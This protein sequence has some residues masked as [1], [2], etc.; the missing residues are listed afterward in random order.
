[1]VRLQYKRYSVEVELKLIHSPHDCKALLLD[2][3]VVPLCRGQFLAAVAHRVGLPVVNLHQHCADSI[4]RRIS[5]K[6]ESLLGVG[7]SQDGSPGQHSSHGLERALLGFLPLHCV[8]LSL[9]QQVRKWHCYSCE[10][11]DIFPIVVG[12]SHEEA[13]LFFGGRSG[14]FHDLPHVVIVQSLH[15]FTQPMSNEVDVIGPQNTFAGPNGEVSF[16]QSLE[17]LFQRLNVIFLTGCVDENIVTAEQDVFYVV[18]DSA[19]SSLQIG[20]ADYHPKR[21]SQEFTMAIR[22]HE[23]SFGKILLGNF[24]LPVSLTQ[25]N[26]FRRTCRCQFSGIIPRSSA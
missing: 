25:I 2:G 17:E 16:L 13:D 11:G 14:C 22:C 12:K 18:Q 8:G 21:H 7:Q 6:D 5:P 9:L 4:I 26:F 19:Q 24:D 10:V 23:S 3:G 1:M 20:T 15:T